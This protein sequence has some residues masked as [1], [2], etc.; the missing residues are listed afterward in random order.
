[1]ALFRLILI[2]FLIYII[3]RFI[4]RLLFPWLYITENNDRNYKRPG[5]SNKT[6]REGDVSLHD[7]RGDKEK[8]IQKDEGD[9]IDYEEIK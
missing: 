8:I 5:S 1:M 2:A 7:I 4:G 6:G 3:L 9:Y